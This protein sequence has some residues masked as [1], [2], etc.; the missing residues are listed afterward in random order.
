MDGALAYVIA[1]V[2]LAGITAAASFALRRLWRLPEQ[3]CPEQLP[4]FSARTY[5]PLERLFSPKDIEFL[6]R[7]PGYTRKLEAGFRRKRAEAFRLYLGAI[8]RD[9]RALHAAARSMAAQGVGNADLSSK[10]LEMRI[11]FQRTLIVARYQAFLFEHGWV[12][13]APSVQPL[14]DAM[15]AV[16]Q[17]AIASAAA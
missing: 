13:P 4:E 1:A 17:S 5:A 10:L 8:Q 11:E 7:Q 14:V 3:P 2:G 16:R 9:Y 15:L 6:K 12:V